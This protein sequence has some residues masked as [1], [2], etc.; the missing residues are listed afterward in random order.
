MKLYY[1]HTRPIVPAL[2]E[3]KE[4]KHPGHILYGLTH[5]P[6]YGIKPILHPYR[7]F[8]SRKKLM[9]YNL[10]TIGTNGKNSIYS[11]EPP[12]GAWNCLSSCVP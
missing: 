6:K 4:H 3:W 5:F 12:T 7:H 10:C 9:W 1:Y 2:E 8:T 11:T